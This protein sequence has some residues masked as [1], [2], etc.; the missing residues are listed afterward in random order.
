[1]TYDLMSATFRYFLML[2]NKLFEG[3]LQ[4]HQNH[5]TVHATE[6]PERLGLHVS[7]FVF[8]VTLVGTLNLNFPIT[9]PKSCL[10]C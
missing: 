2:N 10:C 9:P 3:L 8:F 6:L 1:M 7:D 4:A 5:D